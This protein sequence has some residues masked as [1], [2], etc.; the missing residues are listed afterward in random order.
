LL[1]GSNGAFS[2]IKS[3]LVCGRLRLSLHARRQTKKATANGS[4]WHYLNIPIIS[5]QSHWS[6]SN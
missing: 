5:L 2:I 6:A 4:S 1:G 3:N